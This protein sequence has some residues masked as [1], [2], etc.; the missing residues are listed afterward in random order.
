ML[1]VFPVLPVAPVA[2]LLPVPPVG[3]AKAHFQQVK[4][5]VVL[6]R[7]YGLNVTYVWKMGFSGTQPLARVYAKWGTNRMRSMLQ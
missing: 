7:S 2:P 5:D 3:L 4:R 1:P 6:M